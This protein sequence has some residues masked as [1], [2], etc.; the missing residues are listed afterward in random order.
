MSLFIDHSLSFE[1]HYDGLFVLHTS[2]K[3][4]Q[5]P[6]LNHSYHSYCIMMIKKLCFISVSIHV[7]YLSAMY[8]VDVIARYKSIRLL[9]PIHTKKK[10]QSNK[11]SYQSQEEMK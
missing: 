1:Y 5:Q 3:V 10:K 11:F 4:P 6:L 9:F 7:S 8:D 2:I